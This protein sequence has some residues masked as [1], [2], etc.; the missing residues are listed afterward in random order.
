M[1]RT[2]QKDVT[3]ESNMLFNFRM[4]VLEECNWNR[5]QAAEVLGVQLRT[6]HLQLARYREEGIKIPES[7]D[8]V[9]LGQEF[10]NKLDAWV[11]GPK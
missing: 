6:F 7:G 1:K 2:Y 8:R 5:K 9:K 3:N 4:W 11:G 10:W